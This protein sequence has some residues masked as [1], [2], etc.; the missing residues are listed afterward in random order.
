MSDKSDGGSPL[1]EVEPL[2]RKH[3]LGQFDCGR[4][5]SL[6]IWLKRFS[7]KNQSSETAR[8]YVGHRENIVVGY[9]SIS[10]G[11]VTK[12]AAPERISRGLARHPVPVTLLARS[13]VD[14]TAQGQGLGAA[15][16]K[17]A[18]RRIA[19]AADILGIRA[20]LVHAIDAEAGRFYKKFGFEET[21]IDDLHLMLLMKDLRSSL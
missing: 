2:S 16:L 20:V 14:K 1:F 10:A 6:N 15:L 11:S 3:D 17:D 13:A 8:T 5:E 18:L 19:T 4:H 9:Y 21:P 7:L 12:E